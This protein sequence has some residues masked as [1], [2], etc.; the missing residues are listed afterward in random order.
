MEDQKC[1]APAALL[2]VARL[3]ASRAGDH[4]RR[5]QSRSGDVNSITQQDVKHKLDIECE[6]IVKGVIR[7]CRP[8]DHILAEESAEGEAAV[9]PGAVQWVVDPIDGTVNFFHGMPM[10]CCSVAAMVDGV[11]QAGVVYAPALGMLFEATGDGPALCNGD[12]IA[13]SRTARLEHAMLNT[14]SGRQSGTDQGYRILHAIIDTVQRPRIM[15]AAAL[16]LCLVAS[17]RSDAYFE[18]GVYIWDVAAGGLILERAGGRCEVIKRYGD[19]KMAVL[20]SNG[21]LH[22]GLRERLLPL[23]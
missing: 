15:G 13:V 18:F 19:H 14:G 20:G 11:S 16:D 1:P 21:L 6:E 5:N 8:A 17:G 7:T 4:A 2:A 23:A 9:P 3:A 12:P 10:W 22:A